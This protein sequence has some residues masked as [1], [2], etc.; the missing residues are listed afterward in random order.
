MW[1]R[2]CELSLAQEKMVL[3]SPSPSLLTFS[4]LFWVCE[5]KEKPKKGDPYFP[6]EATFSK[7]LQAQSWEWNL[8]GRQR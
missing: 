5:G 6:E 1:R 2:L 3:T 4:N 8:L 7:H